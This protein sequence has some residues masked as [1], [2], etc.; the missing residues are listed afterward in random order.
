MKRV[1]LVLALALAFVPGLAYAEAVG[2]SGTASTSSVTVTVNAP[3]IIVHND[4]TSLSLW[5][6]VFW[7]GETPAAATAAV[8]SVEIKYGEAYQ[9]QKSMSIK[10]VSLI[11][12]S[13]TVA[14]RIVSF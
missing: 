12:A 1:I 10:A 9:F 7:E 11:T 14:Y 5:V 8:P 6:R 4:S 2:S 13:S 3:S